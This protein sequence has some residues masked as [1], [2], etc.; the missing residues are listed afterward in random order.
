[1]NS[2]IFH[3]S[4]Y[5][6]VILSASVDCSSFLNKTFK[7]IYFLSDFQVRFYVKSNCVML[8]FTS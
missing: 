7:Y 6:I 2:F 1:M 3:H 4:F 8:W 5:L